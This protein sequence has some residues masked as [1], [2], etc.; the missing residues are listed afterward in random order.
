MKELTN[1]TLLLIKCIL[2]EVYGQ[3]KCWVSKGE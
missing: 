3:I 1:E 2:K